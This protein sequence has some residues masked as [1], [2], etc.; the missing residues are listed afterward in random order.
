[1]SGRVHRAIPRLALSGALS[2]LLLAVC[3]SLPH[4]NDTTAALLLVLCILGISMKWGW[5]E[6][7][8]A[9]IVGGSGYD[10][11]FLG[12]TGFS[13]TAPEY[14]VALAAFLITAIVTGHLAARLERRRV[15]AERQKDEAE[16]LYR[17][18]NALLGS[19]AAEFSRARLADRLVEIF[20][21]DGVALYDKATGRIVRSGQ[22][23]GAFSDRALHEAA[24]G[25]RLIED[26]GLAL[27]VAP[28]RHGSELVGSLGISG[29]KLSEP[30]LADVARNVGL[31]LARLYA[32]ETTT[33]AEI[34]RRTEEL[35]SAILDAMA[36]EIRN[37][38]N[39]IKMA[40]TTLLSKHA[41][42]ELDQRE[43]LAI[44]DE[45]AT[46]MDRLLDE[47]VQMARVEAKYLS[48]RKEPHD[49]ARLIP[50][51]IEEIHPLAGGRPI[52]VSVP[53]SLPPPECDGD[54]IVRV[55]KQLVSNA[56]KYSPEGSPLAV[57]AQVAGEAV[58]IDVVDGGPG[59]HEE[60]RER[61]FEKY[62]RGRAARSAA[63]GTGLGLASARSIVQAHGGEIWLTHPPGG[64][65]AFHVSLP[66]KMDNSR[67]VEGND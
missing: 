52:H 11:Y 24:T 22:G 64:G 37:P 44:I 55:I 34:L 5:A 15:D 30:F 12:S 18:A 50:A 42:S 13:I 40:A 31:G 48:L 57:S 2:A 59:V 58:V 46:R 25:G 32:M 14:G 51:A 10:Y 36:H 35:K 26:A 39:S 4:I 23:S 56:L 62:Y 38:L 20:G 27:S 1:M 41:G 7:F 9:A 63:P 17:L 60:D 45:E 66:V 65:A 29:A 61:I 6:A 49:L 8:T 54:M 28:I 21:A 16:K 53:E 67:T 3:I 47:G 19:S 43:M 33:E